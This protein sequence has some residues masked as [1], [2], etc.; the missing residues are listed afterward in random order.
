MK[1]IHYIII[2]LLYFAAASSYNDALNQIALY[3]AI[4][5]AFVLSL[6]SNRQKVFANKYLNILLLMYLWVLFTGLFSI[7]PSRTYRQISQIL[8]VILISLTVA[9]LSKNKHC[10]PWLYGI[11]IVLAFAIFTYVKNNLLTIA[12][13]ISTS[14][15]GDDTLNTNKIAYY[16]F[17]VTS[18]L[19]IF[20]TF[21]YK[22]VI[23]K[24]FRILFLLMIPATFV[25]ALYTASRQIVVI[26]IPLFLLLIYIR[27]FKTRK[28]ALRNTVILGAV[29]VYVTATY[30]DEIINTYDNSFLKT[31]SEKR[32]EDDTRYKLLKQ[33]IE[34][35]KDNPIVGVGPG[36]FAKLQPSHM[37]SH[38]T[39][40]ELF[41]NSGIPALLLFCYAIFG[42]IKCTFLDYRKSKKSE[43]LAFA[44]ITS[45]YALYNVFYVFYVDLW[46]IGFFTLISSHYIQIKKDYQHEHT[47][48][49]QF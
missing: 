38:C 20:G 7:E 29:L 2:G 41:A 40:T 31:R 18:A 4:P 3:A 25:I 17:F 8:G 30:S 43:Y 9:N 47:A 26:Q 32:V 24:T 34:V 45:I 23:K 12:Y 37:F 22:L 10:I 14:R 33:A 1:F 27:Y 15:I 35:G 49:P 11:Y 6:L 21:D 46:M 13:D 39:Y 28:Y 44:A 16:T 19:Y 36:C 48:T 42:F 5:A